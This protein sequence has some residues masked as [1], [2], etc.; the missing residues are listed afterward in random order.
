M[1]RLLL[2]GTGSADGWPNAFCRCASCEDARGR[3]VVRGQ[4]AALLDGTV[5]LDCGPEVPRAAVRAGADLGG[6]RL[7][8]LTHAHP[9]HTS[10]AALLWRSWAGADEPLVV[11]GP[12]PAVAPH[13]DWLAPGSPVRLVPLSPGDDLRVDGP[14]GAYRVRAVAGA[15]EVPALLYLLD[16]PD[17][18]R[19]LYATDTGP[20]PP[21]TLAALE[22]AEVDLLVLEETFGDRADHGTGH[23][24]LTTFPRV[25]ADLRRA[26]AVTDRTRVVATHL[27]H[28]NPPLPQLHER[29]A[30]WGAEVHPDGTVLGVGADA[31]QPEHDGHAAT[32]PPRRTLVL[33]GARSGKSTHAERL[34]AD[35]D[36]VVYVA[37]AGALRGTDGSAPGPADAEWADRVAAH[38]A[39]RPASWTTLE[40]ADLVPLLRS[41]GPPLLVDCLAL[42]ATARLTDAGAWDEG[43][44]RAGTARERWSTAVDDLLGAWR[45]TTRTVVAVSNEVGGGVVP[46]T[47]SGRLF[48]DE[49]G[50]LNAAVAAASERVEL[51]VAGHALRLRG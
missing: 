39:R 40:T 5:L 26:G 43:A 21:A 4:S 50:R 31:A 13:A 30:A 37:T 3:G 14:S 1:S 33:G 51:V 38:R 7:V 2:L 27:S 18:G 41:A 9:D 36:D 22:G 34:L 15:H 29:L 17:G 46:A 44:W 11:A 28:H 6:V 25:L 10:P 35:R 8:L 42:W 16:A 23:L 45:A 49:L 32:T 12:E 24:D 48:R 19:V 20:L 47:W